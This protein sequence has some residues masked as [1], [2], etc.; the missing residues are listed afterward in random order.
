MVVAIFHRDQRHAFEAVEEG[1]GFPPAM[2]L[3]DT[4]DNIHAFAPPFV[5]RLEHR[6]SLADAG[7]GAEKDL[8]AAA[9]LSLR[10]R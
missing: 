3:D 10:L 6:V 2:C 4:G 5:R 7:G 1:L 9:S 8:Q